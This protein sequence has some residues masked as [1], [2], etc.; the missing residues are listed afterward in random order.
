MRTT[1]KTRNGAAP[2]SSQSGIDGRI[3]AGAGKGG[4]EGAEKGDLLKLW[5]LG[6]AVVVDRE[7][8]RSGGQK[9]AE[10]MGIVMSAKLG[11]FEE[12]HSFDIAGGLKKRRM[13]GEIDGLVVVIGLRR[14]Y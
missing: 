14:S 12:R 8:E 1:T 2:C 13:G 3:E 6:A 5:T 10:P 9:N 4:V 7:C 11:R